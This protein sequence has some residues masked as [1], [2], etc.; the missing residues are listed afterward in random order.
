[1]LMACTIPEIAISI[2]DC[3]YYIRQ[4]MWVWFISSFG[5]VVY[6]YMGYVMGVH[7]R[8][9]GSRVMVLPLR[10]SNILAC[11]SSTS[12]QWREGED[13]SKGILMFIFL[14]QLKEDNLYTM[15]IHWTS[16][17]NVIYTVWVIWTPTY[18]QYV[19]LFPEDDVFSLQ[20]LE[21]TIVLH[22][23]H[24][25]ITLDTWLLT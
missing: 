19:D 20:I 17:T 22:G 3:Q 5:G 10:L 7:C 15:D 16:S 21:E 6:V 4:V 13:L 8:Q 12:C 14:T 23:G 1:M 24:Q 9:E 25:T 18:I 11:S 2:K